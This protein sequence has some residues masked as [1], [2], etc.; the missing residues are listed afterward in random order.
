MTKRPANP[1]ETAVSP[2][3]VPAPTWMN[4]AQKRAFFDL[5]ALEMG[6]KGVVLDSQVE[7]FGD[8]VCLRSRLD[9]LRK[10]M[11]T[12]LRKKDASLAATLNNQINSTIDRAQ[13]LADRLRLSDKESARLEYGNR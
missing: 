2:G 9:G 10:L 3:P 13:R 6:W 8:F 1:Q 11:R 4:P 5:V 12:A 7:L